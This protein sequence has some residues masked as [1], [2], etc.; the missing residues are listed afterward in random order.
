[1]IT[2][3]HCSTNNKASTV[4]D[5]FL[6]AIRTYGLPSRMRSDQGRENILVA[7]HMLEN[8]GLGRGS[9]LTARSNHNQ[10]IERLWRDVPHNFIT[11]YS[12]I[13]KIETFL[14]LKMMFICLHCS[15][16]TSDE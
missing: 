15:M 1:M 7:Q 16:F 9:F 12:I 8:R 5:L 3:L 14:T 10:R 13:L 4:Y 2:F 11:D 6:K